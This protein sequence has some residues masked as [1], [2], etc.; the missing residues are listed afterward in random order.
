MG[1][2]PDAGAG[3]SAAYDARQRRAGRAL[4][5]GGADRSGRHGDSE[6]AADA[7]PQHRRWGPLVRGEPSPVTRAVD[8]LVQPAR[9][10]GL[11]SAASVSAQTYETSFT[12]MPKPKSSGRSRR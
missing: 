1:G 10:A 2:A 11:T 4:R 8:G 12:E 7:D 3:R 5:H 6:H 9:V